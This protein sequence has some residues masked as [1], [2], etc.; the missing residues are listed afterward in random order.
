MLKRSRKRSMAIRS[1]CRDG[2]RFTELAKSACENRVG[3]FWCLLNESASSD[4]CRGKFDVRID[5][6]LEFRN[7][8][9]FVVG[10]RDVH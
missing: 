9:V 6:A 4:R 2:K 8:D 7:A 10:V 1:R 5:G 3:T